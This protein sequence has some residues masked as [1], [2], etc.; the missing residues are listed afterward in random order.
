MTRQ[1][2]SVVD[3]HDL[4]LADAPGVADD[5]D[6][7]DPVVGH[8]EL[9]YTAD[10]SAGAHTSAAMASTMASCAPWA[11]PARTDATAAAP[12]SSRSVPMRCAAA[13]GRSTTSGS[14]RRTSASKSHSRAARR[15]ASRHPAGG[16]GQWPTS[17]PCPARA[18]AP[19][20][21]VGVPQTENVPRSRRPP[22]RA[23]RAHRAAR[24]RPARP[25]PGSRAP[26][27][28]PPRWI[29]PFPPAPPGR[30]RPSDLRRHPE[31]ARR[32]SPQAGR[33]AIAA[34]PGTRAP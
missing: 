16:Q 21:P 3:R 2:P 8:P 28:G 13:S 26:R 34:D 9:D 30:D 17:T 22:R 29:R 33:D 25:E 7:D 20:W 23:S 32:S 31:A 4:E 27:A 11:P 15:N 5:I 19:G 1:W 12:C 10:P 6:G 14:S 24:T 18:G